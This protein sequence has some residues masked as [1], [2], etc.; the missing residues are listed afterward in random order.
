MKNAYSDTNIDV[1]FFGYRPWALKIANNL[2]NSH[3]PYWKIAKIIK[4]ED[5]DLNLCLKDVNKDTILLFYGWSWKIPKEIYEKHL[6]LILHTS[7][8]PK[9]R[10]GSPLQHQIIAGEKTSAVTICKVE[11]QID[12][13]A[14]Y[15]QTPFSLDGSLEHILYV[16]AEIGTIDTLRVL[17]AIARFKITPISQDEEQAT[18]FKRRKPE[19]SELTIEDLK[20]MTAKQIYNFIRAL[21][22]PYPNA[23][24]RSR[25][26]KKVYLT[27][28]KI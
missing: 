22:D 16:I 19:E 3:Y 27:G 28:A 26:G 25:D 17:D 11:E 1:I 18:L 9:Y 12:S 4:E 24:I 14:I 13:G 5:P 20:T 8:L 10:G 23:F 6:C 21:A 7:P 15:S 2:L